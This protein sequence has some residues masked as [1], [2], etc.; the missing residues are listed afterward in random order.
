MPSAFR[1]SSWLDSLFTPEELSRIRSLPT[2]QNEYGFDPFGFHRDTFKGP[3]AGSRW[4]YRRYFRCEV[5]GLEHVPPGRVLLVSNHS[6]K[7][8]LT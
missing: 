2:R 3:L 7:P 1:R 6:V 8:R 4:L 5:H